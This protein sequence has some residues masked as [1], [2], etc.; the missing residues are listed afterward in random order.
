MILVECELI[1]LDG[2][3]TARLEYSLPA[4]SGSLRLTAELEYQPQG[5]SPAEI[6][7]WADAE[8]RTRLR[9]GMV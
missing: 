5:R 8:A 2:R 6:E 9:R 3:S 4:W 1:E 7:A